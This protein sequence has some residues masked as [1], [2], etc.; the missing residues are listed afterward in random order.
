MSQRLKLTGREFIDLV[1]LSECEPLDG[2]SVWLCRCKCGAELKVLGFKLTSNHTKRCRAC[3]WKAA[4]NKRKGGE[5]SQGTWRS[6]IN[7]AK[8]RDILLNIS[9]EQAYLKFLEQNKKCALTGV[10]I[11]LE[12]TTN[13]L[14]HNIT[15]SLDRIDSNKPYE[16]GNIQWVHKCVN[17]LK[18]AMSEDEFIKWCCL[19]ADHKRKENH[20]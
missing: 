9:K 8:Q 20:G 16:I 15:A 3:G 12:R 5:L 18:R 11:I 6:I 13:Q 1:V 4:G 14:R 2:K 7:A 19:V 10:E 17:M